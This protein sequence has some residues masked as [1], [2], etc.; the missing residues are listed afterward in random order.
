MARTPQISDADYTE[1][2]QHV[3]ESG[4]DTSLVRKVPQQ[5]MV[6]RQP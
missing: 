2:L 3:S 5:S 1:M 4:Y 6:E